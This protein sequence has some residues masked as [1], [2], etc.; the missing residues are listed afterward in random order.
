M[1]GT[2]EP[3]SKRT[4]TN[5]NSAELLQANIGRRAVY[6]AGGLKD[7]TWHPHFRLIPAGLLL[8]VHALASS[9][10]P[11]APAAAGAREA[12][13]EAGGGGGDGPEGTAYNETRWMEEIGEEHMLHTARR[14]L[15]ALAAPPAAAVAHASEH[16]EGGAGVGGE[17]WATGSGSGDRR[18]RPG[19]CSANW[20]ARRS[21][22][23]CSLL[24]GGREVPRVAAGSWE[25]KVVLEVAAALLRSASHAAQILSRQEVSRA[26]MRECMRTYVRAC[27]RA[28]AC[29]CQAPT[30]THSHTSAYVETGKES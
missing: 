9:Q 1:G 14:I 2:G 7:D 21:P 26:C 30:C 8:R 27:V 10:G 12:G 15:A 20:L 24:G 29:L 11:H 23:S 28:T 16:G 5:F 4:P 25:A 3:A 22:D 18:G 19:V 17:E 6:V 13:G